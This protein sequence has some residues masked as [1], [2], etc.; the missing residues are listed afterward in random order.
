MPHNQADEHPTQLFASAPPIATCYWKRL[1]AL[2][3][4]RRVGGRWEQCA[5]GQ[6]GG[7]AGANARAFW[8]S[9]P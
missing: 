4:G 2:C 8:I 6:V 1:D 7:I 9:T 5:I 3:L